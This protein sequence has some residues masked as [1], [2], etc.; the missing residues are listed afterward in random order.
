MS[1]LIVR[2]RDLE[3][4]DDERE[5]KRL[6]TDHSGDTAEVAANAEST[7]PEEATS[8]FSSEDLLPP[9]KAL[10]PHKPSGLDIYRVSE[11]DVGISEYISHDVPRID[12]IIKQR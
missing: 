3:Q 9:S 2:E 5:T 8:M 7:R 12:G 1:T 10:L 11:P 4:S 6:K